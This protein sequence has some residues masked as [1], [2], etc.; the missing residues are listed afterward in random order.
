MEYRSGHVLTGLNFYDPA[1]NSFIYP[2]T[3]GQSY[4]FTN[5]GYWEQA[6][7]LYNTNPAKPNCVSA[8][9]IWQHGTYLLNSN[10]TLTLNI[11]KGDGRQQVSSRCAENSNYVQSY[12]QVENMQGF[13]I[14]LDTHYNSPAYVLKMYEF[15]GTPKPLMYQ[16]FNL[17]RCCQQNRYTSK[18][19]VSSMG[20]KRFV[21]HRNERRS[22]STVHPRDLV[23]PACRKPA[24]LHRKELQCIAFPSSFDVAPCL[25]RWNHQTRVG[26]RGRSLHFFSHLFF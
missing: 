7:Y 1:N 17:P 12:D 16:V 15:D 3:A 6:L 20:C 21:V 14:H 4:S 23:H 2:T 22:A 25:Y 11:F 19:L 10:N 8:Q 5:D 13:E 9:L 24:S 18:S 26:R